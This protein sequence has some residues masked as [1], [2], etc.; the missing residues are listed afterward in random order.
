MTSDPALD[1]LFVP[2]VRGTLAWP[3]R[4][5]T[6]FLRARVGGPVGA[7][8]RRLI[9]Q[10]SF[11][12]RADA[13]T[14]VGLTPVREAGPETH[15]LVLVLPPRQR[16]AARA[17]LAEA[18][19]RRAPGGRVVAA[20]L[21][22]EGARAIED[23][24]ARLCGPIES[25]SKHKA[26]VFWTTTDGVDE[27]LLARWLDEAAPRPI[28]DGA[29]LSRPGLFSWER[30][31]QGS[32]L[33]IEALPADLA[34]HGADLG[35]GIGVLSAAVLE[36]CAGVTALDLHE[37]ESLALDLARRNLPAGPVPLAF[38]WADVTTGLDRRYDFIVMNPPFHEGRADA[39]AL[40][41]AFIR[42][43]ATGL[44]PKGRLLMVANR[45]L[46]YEAVLAEL[47]RQ[48]ETLI[49]RDGYKVIEAG[50]SILPAARRAGKARPVDGGGPSKAGRRG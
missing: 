4:G 2:F 32:A 30:L 38:H 41:Q 18:V 12:P 27:A 40:G 50:G 21:N 28:G 26:R 13:L 20:A 23:D 17:A 16:E 10:Q 8:G 6:L 33:L 34:G 19:A 47:F 49:D 7:E 15:E 24:L 29:F 11:K 37:A 36:R 31:D 14:R 9:A 44:K 48:R 43:A 22:T 39:N 46:P 35:A 5:Q 1:A 45:H 25:L 42:A 3:D